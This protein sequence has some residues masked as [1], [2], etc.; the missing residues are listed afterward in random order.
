MSRRRLLSPEFGLIGTHREE[1][2]AQCAAWR[3]PSDPRRLRASTSI[4]VSPVASHQVVAQSRLQRDRAADIESTGRLSHSAGDSDS[5]SF[6]STNYEQYENALRHTMAMHQLQA[7]VN[8][9]LI[10][11]W[12]GH[13]SI[14]TTHM[15]IEA[16][17]AMK[18]RALEKVKSVEGSVGRFRPSDSLLAFLASL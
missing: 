5:K 2:S 18:E 6:R 15:Y 3:R 1:R 11:L 8:I 4:P 16:D 17:L 7:G 13:E 14:E 10:S 9:E 12:L